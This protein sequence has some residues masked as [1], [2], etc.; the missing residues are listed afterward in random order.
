MRKTAFFLLA[1]LTLAPVYAGAGEETVSFKITPPTGKT[2]LAEVFKLKVEASIPEKYSIRPDTASFEGRDFGLLSFSGSSGPA[3]G[4]MKTETFELRLQGFSL[5]ISTFPELSWT[6]YGAGGAGEA[7]AKSPSFTMELAPAFEN[8]PGEDIRDIYPPFRYVP[9]LR[10]LAGALAAAAAAFLLYRRLSR[11]RARA[12]AAAW[13]DPRPPYQCAR[14]RLEGMGKSGLAAAGRLK[15]YYIGLTAVLRFYLA[16]E[17]FIS[18]DLMTTSD[19]TRELKKT[20]ADIKTT[21]RAREFLQ[22]ADLV[23]FARL[24]PENAEADASALAN[25]LSAFNRAA[26]T[27]RDAAKTAPAEKKP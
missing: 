21:L 24:K 4:G 26:E 9:W 5:G 1:A 6:L 8:K 15:E 7:S 22:K 12:A 16:E 25:L 14:D 23:K 19:L 13:T 17:F 11:G 27:A 3:A 18:A 10:L 2:R 20:G